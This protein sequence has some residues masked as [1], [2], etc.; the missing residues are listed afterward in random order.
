MQISHHMW[1][2]VT[3]VSALTSADFP[4]QR[5]KIKVL[6]TGDYSD[7]GNGAGLFISTLHVHT[8]YGHVPFIVWTR[9]VG[10]HGRVCAPHLIS[11]PVSKSHNF[12]GVWMHCKWNI[13]AAQI[14]PSSLY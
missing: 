3:M 12:A 14:T 11:Y 6:A 7:S 10:E 9:P 4:S 2:L 1:I 13:V 5:V 8:Y